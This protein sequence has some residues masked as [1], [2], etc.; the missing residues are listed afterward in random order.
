[1]MNLKG[2]LAMRNLIE[3]SLVLF[4]CIFLLPYITEGQEMRTINSIPTPSKLKKEGQIVQQPIP[5]DNEKVRTKV[6]GVFNN[7][8]NGDIGG[9]L[10]DAFYDKSRF[11]NA[12]Q[13]NI[14]KDSRLKIQ[15]MGSVQ[16]LEQRIVNNSDGSQRRI[17]LGSVTVNSQ[18]EFNDPQNGFVRVPGT[19]E[20]LFEM[21]EKLK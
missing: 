2:V 17:T 1:M 16:T 13:T 18:L 20:I 4:A 7:W 11:Q 6:E 3:V 21:V 10:S 19:N 14:P 9:S 15:G 8:N 5:L 12:M